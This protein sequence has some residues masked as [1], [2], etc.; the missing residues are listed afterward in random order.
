VNKAGLL[1]A[2]LGSVA[3]IVAIVNLSRISGAMDRLDG[4]KGASAKAET[5]DEPAK[6]G[7]SDEERKAEIEWLKGEAKRISAEVEKARLEI[8][9]GGNGTGSVPPT[10]NPD[11][12]TP[13]V[14]TP[15]DVGIV[16]DR[17]LDQRWKD[18]KTREA[19]A[20]TVML[21]RTADAV[22]VGLETKCKI[23][24]ATK[25]QV[26]A[27]LKDTVEGIAAVLRQIPAPADKQE[28][29]NKVLQKS[30]EDMKR[31]LSPIQYT[32]YKAGGDWTGFGHKVEAGKGGGE[33]FRKK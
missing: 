2:G 25:G 17:I 32:T 11:G 20:K 22:L 30:D 16:I 1:G 33:G 10:P 26:Q 13:L 8:A 7:L 29:I 9:K 23:E 4:L 27:I 18:Q 5:T 14:L 21:E 19:E 31:I 24:P 3:I 15:A 28:Q 12:S 6:S